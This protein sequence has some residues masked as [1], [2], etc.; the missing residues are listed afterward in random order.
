MGGEEARQRRR[1]L[2]RGRQAHAAQPRRQPLEPRE[3]E[4]QL[5]AALRF[6]QR[7]DLVHD[8]PLQA[9]KDPRRILVGQEQREA[10]GRRQQDVGRI[11]ALPAADV[12]AGVAGAVLDPDGETRAL[13][14]GAEVAA[15]VGGQRLQRR[16]V[17]RVEARP[18][19][20]AKFG[21]RGQEPGQRL[22][23]ARGRHEEERGLLRTGQHLFLMRVERPAAGVEIG[24]EERRQRAHEQ[25]IGRGG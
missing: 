8:H 25:R 11:G 22:A 21:Q 2:D 24:G 7:M 19:R 20:G 18:R 1:I 14:R 15:D 13:D 17:E 23:A 3:A 5:V 4:H 12:A 6:G 9:G 16:D 10:F